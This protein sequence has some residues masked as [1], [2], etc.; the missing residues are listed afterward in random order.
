MKYSGNLQSIHMHD[1][2]PVSNIVKKQLTHIIMKY[3]ED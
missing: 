2:E 3:I 1:N